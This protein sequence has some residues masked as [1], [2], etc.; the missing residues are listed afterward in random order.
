MIMVRVL[1][2]APQ[3]SRLDL[4][5]GNFRQQDSLCVSRPRLPRSGSTSRHVFDRTS[6]PTGRALIRGTLGQ[7]DQCRCHLPLA[8]FSKPAESNRLLQIAGTG[9]ELAEC[10]EGTGLPADVKAAQHYGELE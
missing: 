3:R 4:A 9:G 8:G 7:V 2:A 5:R 10:I 6:T 1:A